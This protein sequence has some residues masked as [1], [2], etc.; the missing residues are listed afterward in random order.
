MAI[1]QPEKPWKN[2]TP[3]PD[4]DRLLS[5]T[6]ENIGSVEAT[7]PGE[8]YAFDAD[9]AMIDEVAPKNNFA[10]LIEELKGKEPEAAAALFSAFGTEL[11][12]KVVETAEAHKDRAWEMIEICAKQ[13][14]ISFPHLLQAPAELF[15]LCSRPVDKWAMV[16]SHTTK[17]RVQQYTCSYLKAQQDAGLS[18]EG[19]PCRALCLAA[20]GYAAKMRN[21][22]V[23]V[24]LTKQLTADQVCEFTFTPQQG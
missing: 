7:G 11:M 18:T 13:T 23:T 22:P 5:L 17:M 2:R 9:R 24:E 21:M 16:E 15:S 8:E 12:E 19:L 6:P 20:F 4:P 14:G 1:G 10:E 3:R